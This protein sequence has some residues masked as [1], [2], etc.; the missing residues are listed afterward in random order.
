VVLIGNTAHASSLADDL[1]WKTAC[2]WRTLCKLLATISDVESYEMR[3]KSRVKWV[4]Q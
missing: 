2:F 1:P 3:R 4:Q